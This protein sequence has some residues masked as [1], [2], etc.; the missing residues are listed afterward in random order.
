MYSLILVAFNPVL[1]NRKL[2]CVLGLNNSQYT[3][4]R[5][6][7]DNKD[8]AQSMDKATDTPVNGMCY[9]EKCNTYA[10]QSPQNVI[11]LMQHNVSG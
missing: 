4:N 9:A 5:L 7:D 3:Y 1:R 8:V 6:I 11:K 2:V 10:K